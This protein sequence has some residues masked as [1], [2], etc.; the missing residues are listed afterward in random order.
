MPIYLG[1]LGV[2]GYGHELAK[3][4]TL[5]EDCLRQINKAAKGLKHDCRNYYGN[6]VDFCR[7]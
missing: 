2:S 5:N 3:I 6:H 1:Y 4:S 7:K